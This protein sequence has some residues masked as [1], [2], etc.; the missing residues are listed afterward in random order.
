MIHLPKHLWNHIS[1]IKPMSVYAMIS[2]TST[3]TIEGKEKDQAHL[4]ILNVANAQER[5]L[6]GKERKNRTEQ[7]WAS[8]IL[9]PARI[10]WSLPK[11]NNAGIESGP[12]D[13]IS[14]VLILW[15]WVVKSTWRDGKGP[16]LYR[17]FWSFS[18]T[19]PATAPRFL[20]FSIS[21]DFT[22]HGCRISFWIRKGLFPEFCSKEYVNV[23]L[24]INMSIHKNEKKNSWQLHTYSHSTTYLQVACP[25]LEIVLGTQGFQPNLTIILLLKTSPRSPN[26]RNLFDPAW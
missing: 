6:Q 8:C 22:Y 9:M 19:C 2:T 4:S 3:E 23:L 13:H 25:G 16:E 12:L 18:G 24:G 20:A 21:H 26:E 5:S 10:S 1:K 17:T 11:G 15:G 14:T 7:M